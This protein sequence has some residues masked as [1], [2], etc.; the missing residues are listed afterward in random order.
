[1][2]WQRSST[3]TLFTIAVGLLVL[4]A[5][6]SGCTAHAHPHDLSQSPHAALS[7]AGDLT[8]WRPGASKTAIQRFVGRVTREGSADFV[9]PAERIAV[10]DNDG[11]LWSEQ[12]IYVQFA[13][14]IERVKAHIGRLDKALDAAE[15]SGW[16]VVDIARDWS[17]VYPFHK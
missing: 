13:F 5:G 14:A 3:H 1:M 9:P 4:I 2:S 6:R 8:S 15:A 7:P 17:A 12:P 10:F 16:T 11:T